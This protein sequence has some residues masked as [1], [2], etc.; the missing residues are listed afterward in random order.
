MRRGWER[1]ERDIHLPVAETTGYSGPLKVNVRQSRRGWEK[2]ER[3]IHLP[4]AEN[5]GYGGPLKV[6][7]RER[8]RGSCGRRQNER[9]TY[10]S[11]TSHATVDP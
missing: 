2:A 11:Q 5:T 3:E 8:R 7:V 10:Q 1:T 9:F 6:N 4:V